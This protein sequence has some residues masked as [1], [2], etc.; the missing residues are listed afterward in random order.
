M[1]EI[2]IE[3]ISPHPKNPRKALGDLRELTD[4]IRTFGVLQ[5][6]TVIPD[7]TNGY[8]CLCGHR[9]LA[10]AEAA[11]LET[12]PCTIAEGMSEKT[13]VEIMLLENMQR[14]DLTLQEEAQGLQMMLD[15]GSNITEI[16]KQ[17]GMSETKVRHRVKMNELDQELLAEKIAGQIQIND[18]I[19]LEQIKDID[20]RNEL[21]KLAGTNNFDWK[22]REAINDQKKQETIGL[23]RE[24]MPEVSFAEGYYWQYTTVGNLEFGA[25]REE[26]DEF[27]AEMQAEAEQLNK[28]ALIAERGQAFTIAFEQDEQTE[29][30][31]DREAEMR[32][33]ERNRRIE[34]LREM[35]ERVI[36]SWSDFMREC[37]RHS[38]SWFGS[39]QNIILDT[40]IESTC[41]TN[42]YGEVDPE[43]VLDMLGL[44]E[45]ASIRTLIDR[46]WATLAA[47]AYSVAAP[48]RFEMT[49][50]YSDLKYNE[51][52]AS[53]Y[54]AAADYIE[55]LGYK[56]SDDEIAFIGGTSGL[57]E[58]EEE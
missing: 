26:V 57:Y 37:C 5:N 29:T 9:R 4:S 55:L 20:K 1:R 39:K 12:V 17:T 52:G 45:K 8:I 23:I 16:V 34:A 41:D 56:A 2:L 42:G 13:Q 43:E 21:L 35:R 40:L 10:A 32:R 38:E 18:L 50:N 22:Y 7:G 25:T 46:R 3:S 24:I 53:K 19:R 48:S 31:K 49:W 11:G 44:D 54:I 14:N 27:V 51:D 36:A 33:E 15:L 58:R 6:L 30:E 47:M 28:P